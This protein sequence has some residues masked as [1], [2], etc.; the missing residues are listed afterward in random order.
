MSLWNLCNDYYDY[1]E[2][3]HDFLNSLLFNI[4]FMNVIE[5]IS[6][7]LRSSSTVYGKS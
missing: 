1:R 7:N 5:E 6:Y 2:N 4:Y 3:K